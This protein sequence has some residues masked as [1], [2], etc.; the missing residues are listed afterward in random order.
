MVA[1]ASVL[2]AMMGGPSN[3]AAAGGHRG[4]EG[5][6][7]NASEKSK[8]VRRANI[9][10]AKAVAD[11]VRTSLGP[12]GMDKM[13]QTPSGEVIITND[14]ATIL[15]QMNVEHPAAKMLVALSKAQD[16]V[17]GDGTTSVVVICGSLLQATLE[18]LARGL[19]PATISDAFAVALEKSIAIVDRM[20][21]PISLTDRPALM[22]AASTALNSKVV[23]QHAS[24]LAPIAVDAVLRIMTLKTNELSAGGVTPLA[25]VAAAADGVGEKLE[26][27]AG[28]K[29]VS[30]NGSTAVREA[31]AGT[32]KEAADG[33]AAAGVAG[34]KG[35]VGDAATTIAV[36]QAAAQGSVVDLKNIRTVKKLGGTIDDTEMIDGLILTQ[37]AARGGSASVTRVEK[38]KVALIQFCLS[39][40]KTDVENSVIVQ[41]YSAMDR[42]LREE[43][44][45]ILAMC[46]KIKQAGCNVVL[47]QKS[48]LR[49]ATTDL[50]LH[51]LAKMKIMVA[52][53]IERDEI[54]FISK[55]LGCVPIAGIENFSAD[56]LAKVDLVEEVDV[57]PEKMIKMTGVTRNARTRP[58]VSILVRGSNQLV[59]D[60]AERSLHD[61]I[62]VIRSIVHKG[63]LLPGGGA[64]EAEVSVALGQQSK[65]MTGMQAYCVA[66]Y[67]NA[68]DVVPYTL[69][70]NAGLNAVEIVTEL[71]RRHAAGESDAGIN[72]RKGAVTNISD[73]SVVM[74]YLVFSSALSLA[75][76]QVRALLRIDDIVMT[77]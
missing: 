55:S 10:A 63:F 70:E 5:S 17:A 48:I 45:Y 29:G 18:L 46:K 35:V 31:V 21:T 62:C 68:L 44:Q 24:L 53:D 69:A 40:P 61:A 15:D 23:A 27:G 37:E 30:T 28:G 65:S 33:K 9:A 60:E 51:F 32:G 67:A 11:C 77:R 75:T 57:G 72:V 1:A 36:A 6:N 71:R 58:T 8:D 25:A 54:E 13:I 20:A 66:A 42:I 52:T 43:R 26:A 49:D 7:A 16:T 41:D 73:E 59:L 76:E 22:Q 50:S 14:G 12:R 47:I 56:K 3:G 64:P 74:P 4:G 2:P 34:S 38:A 19:H 39:P